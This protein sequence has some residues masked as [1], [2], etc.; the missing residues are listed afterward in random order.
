MLN[1]NDPREA[2]NNLPGRPLPTISFRTTEPEKDSTR[3]N[4]VLEGVSM[5]QRSI[6]LID[7][8]SRGRLS[9]KIFPTN[10]RALRPVVGE[11]ISRCTLNTFY[12]IP[13]D[14]DIRVD[15]EPLAYD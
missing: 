14:L 4:H 10:T 5:T 12:Q 15:Y 2:L 1:W 7:A 9:S 3:S 8:F 6:E 13:S 11:T